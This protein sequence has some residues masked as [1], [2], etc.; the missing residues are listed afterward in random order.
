MQVG[1][2]LLCIDYKAA[3]TPLSTMLQ[4]GVKQAMAMF[5]AHSAMSETSCMWPQAAPCIYQMLT[6]KASVPSIDC[7]RC[8]VHAVQFS[9]GDPAPHNV[10]GDVLLAQAELA[11]PGPASLAALA[12]AAQEGYGAALTISRYDTDALV[13][14]A[15]LL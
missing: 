8:P 3:G 10:L 2:H 15:R 4:Q 5:A 14:C 12:A 11:G 1:L 7:K 13:S 6:H 9:R